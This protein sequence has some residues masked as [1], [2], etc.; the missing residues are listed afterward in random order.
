[1][2]PA[3]FFEFS[4]LE[5]YEKCNPPH[6]LCPYLFRESRSELRHRERLNQQGYDR[7]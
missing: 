6:V 1:M 2:I 7:L 4:G 5:K 3:K